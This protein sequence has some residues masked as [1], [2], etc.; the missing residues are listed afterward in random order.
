[1]NTRR[2]FGASRQIVFVL[3]CAVVLLASTNLVQAQQEQEAEA[4]SFAGG[5][6]TAVV[7]SS[8]GGEAH[9]SYVFHVRAGRTVTVAISSTANRAQFTVSTSE[10]GEQVNFGKFAKDGRTWTGTIPETGVFFISVV[11]HPIARYTL[12]VR[13]E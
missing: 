9:D 4:L 13:K 12:K 2:M 5:G 10:F 3:A 11:A 8:I 1:M 6:K 7:Q